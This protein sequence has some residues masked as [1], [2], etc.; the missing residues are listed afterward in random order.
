MKIY[1]NYQ[2]YLFFVTLD[3]SMLKFK[4]TLNLKFPGNNET[5]GKQVEING[6]KIYYENM[7]RR[8]VVTDSRQWKVLNRWEIKSIILKLNTEL[9]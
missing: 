7:G 1:L 3:K 4:G 2:K 8:T 6:A 9:S 5:V